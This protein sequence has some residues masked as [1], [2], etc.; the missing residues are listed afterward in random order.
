MKTILSLTFL[1]IFSVSISAKA[2]APIPKNDSRK[3]VDKFTDEIFSSTG[4]L[5]DT[6]PKTDL[7]Q[8]S[9]TLDL[10]G[11]STKWNVAKDGK[12]MIVRIMSPDE[13]RLEF[14]SVQIYIT[15]K[16]FTAKLT[17]A[18]NVL[19]EGAAV[20]FEVQRWIPQNW[21]SYNIPSLNRKV[22]GYLDAQSGGADNA[23][24]ATE[25]F[26]LTTAD[27]KSYWV[28]VRTELGYHKTKGMNLKMALD[29]LKF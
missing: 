26:E 27:G 1:A 16:P 8:P 20:E 9:L 7:P 21:A 23:M 10:P 25:P 2:P 19:D 6:K 18:P 12:S 5:Q 24:Q 4:E 13:K 29:A 15:S 28:L 3:A 22:R 11:W 17:N 14:G